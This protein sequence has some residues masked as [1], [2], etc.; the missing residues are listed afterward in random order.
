MGRAHAASCDPS[1]GRGAPLTRRAFR[2]AAKHDHVA[3]PD[4]GSRSLDAFLIVPFAGLQSTFDVDL[5]SF[6]QILIAD[7]SQTVPHHH[8]VPFGFLL[9]LTR[10]LLVPDV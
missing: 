6:G 10:R 8:I 9:A 3:R 5:L 4:L 2:S 1:R 7:F